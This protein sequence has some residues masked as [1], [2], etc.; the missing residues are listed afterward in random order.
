MADEFGTPEIFHSS[1]NF[2]TG[3]K[4]VIL[5]AANEY[6]IVSNIYFMKSSSLI[7]LFHKSQKTDWY[8]ETPICKNGSWKSL[9]LGFFQAR[10]ISHFYLKKF[11]IINYFGH[12][13]NVLYE[14][15]HMY[16][17]LLVILKNFISFYIRFDHINSHSLPTF[18]GPLSPALPI[19]YSLFSTHQGHSWMDIYRWLR[20]STERAQEGPCPCKRSNLPYSNSPQRSKFLS[21]GTEFVRT[22]HHLCWYLNWLDLCYT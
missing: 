18:P 15:C 8:A 12:S 11:F 19:P 14:P 2:R 7:P 6:W 1:P 16:S 4:Q 13:S 5:L 20:A 22:F 21:C 3:R 10:H 17:F 9:K